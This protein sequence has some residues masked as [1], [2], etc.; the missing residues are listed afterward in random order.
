MIEFWGDMEHG[1]NY[2]LIF[3]YPH[4]HV[5]NDSFDVKLLTY[6]L[7]SIFLSIFKKNQLETVVNFFQIYMLLRT[8]LGQCCQ[9]C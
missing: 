1:Y 3:N 8:S 5:I 7:I 4:I 2:Q 6:V 9:C